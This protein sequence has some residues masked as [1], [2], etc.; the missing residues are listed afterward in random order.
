MI[1]G[2][3]ILKK[4]SV[5]KV[6]GD[7]EVVITD[8]CLDSRQIQPGNL[9]AAMPGTISDGFDFI[10]A[11]IGNGAAVI[12]TEKLPKEIKSEILYIQVKDVRDSLGIVCQTYFGTTYSRLKL[13]G[14]T[15][16][17]GKTTVT[18]LLYDLFQKLGETCGLISTVEYRIGNETFPSTHTTPDVISV[19]RLIQKMTDAGCTYCFMEVS[20]HAADQK[21]IAGLNFTGGVFTNITHDHLDYHKTFDAYIAAKKSFFDLLPSTAFALTNKDEKQGM[22]MTQNTKATKYTYSLHGKG[23]FN[24]RILESD[25]NGTLI[26][27][28][29]NQIWV[30]LV[31]EFN[32][33]NLLAV[34]A[35][36]WLLTAGR[37]DLQVLISGLGRVNGRFEAIPGPGKVTAIVDYAHTPD[38]LKNVLDS[39]NKI[40][41]KGE[42]LIAV[43]GCGGNRDKLKRPEMGKIAAELSDQ[44]II[45]S[46]NPRDEDPG[47][48]MNEIEMGIEGQHYKKVL[49]ISDRKEAI[50]AAVRM[51]GPGDVILI[52]GKGHETYQEIKGNKEPFD[53]KIIV[54]EIFKQLT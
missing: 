36:A 51:A 50:K 1:T 24:C 49:K 20:S 10:D 29:D 38:A 28:N 13:I 35:T 18:T 12:L 46:D 53:D 15:G 22:V 41:T 34:Y 6:L 14:V 25:F 17:N 4:L 42:K 19:Y 31:G 44:V 11:A 43:F 33:Y 52:A 2:A 32:M 26:E 16:T 5:L 54:S 7:T 30:Q 23:D 48:I 21:R 9:Y 37:E 45:T 47:Q 3:D 27:L 8:L 39:I 40:R